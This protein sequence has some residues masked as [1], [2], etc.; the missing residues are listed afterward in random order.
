MNTGQDAVKEIAGE[1]SG[2]ALHGLHGQ[3]DAAPSSAGRDEPKK[4]DVLAVS[5]QVMK[6]SAMQFQ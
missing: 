4:L 2:A 1:I 3:H 5:C 6:I